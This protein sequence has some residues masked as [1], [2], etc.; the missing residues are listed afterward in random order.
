VRKKYYDNYDYEEAYNEQI[1]KLEE[2]EAERIAKKGKG[3][4]YRTTTTEA[5]RMIEVDIYPTFNVRHDMPRTKRG[6][7]SR[8]AQKNL[9]DKRARRYL[10]QLASANFG[11]GDLWGTFTY[12]AGEEPESIDDAEKKFG[13]F[14]RR[15]NRRRK[16]AGKENIK[17][18]YVTEWED[19]EKGVRCHHH[20]ILSGDVDRDEIEQLWYH[21]DRTE[22]KRLAPDP[23]THI[24][25]LVHYITKDPKGKKRWKTS[26]GLKKPTI[27]RS[28]SKFGKAKVRKMAC[29][30]TLL[31]SEL[32]KKYKNARFV[33]A[34]VYQNE[35]N[36]GFYIYARMVR[37]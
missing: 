18:I 3:A 15:I 20:A 4:G 7:E 5:G 36:G 22:T 25:G 37:D 14:I 16:R 34:K 24:A 1:E 21:G 28:Y 19:G 26:K 23:D 10:N 17:Y 30:Y 31:E 35:I 8:P 29:D 13:N 9:N 32:K 11:K 12:R 27:T 33:D 2:A 6:R